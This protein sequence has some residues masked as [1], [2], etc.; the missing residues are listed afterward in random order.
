MERINQ[1]PEQ[2]LKIYTTMKLLPFKVNYKEN[3]RNT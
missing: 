1:E 2:Y 3:E